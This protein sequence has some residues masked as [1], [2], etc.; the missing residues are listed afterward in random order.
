MKAST[1]ASAI[2]CASGAAAYAGR[3]RE[4]MAWLTPLAV[5]KAVNLQYR[6]AGLDSLTHLLVFIGSIK[7]GKSA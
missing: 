1:E 2:T 3:P 4:A 6:Q 5:V 7:A